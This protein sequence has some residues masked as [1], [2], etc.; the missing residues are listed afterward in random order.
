MGSTFNAD[1]FEIIRYS[2]AGSPIPRLF[3]GRN[4]DSGK[5]SCKRPRPVHE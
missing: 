3:G 5:S 4:R 2:L 1:K